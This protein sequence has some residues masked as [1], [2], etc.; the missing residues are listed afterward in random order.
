MKFCQIYTI[1]NKIDK[2]ANMAKM[3]GFLLQY[4]KQLHFNK[5]PAAVRAQFDAYLKAD[6]FRG[7]MKKW[8]D[9]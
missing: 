5:M 4:Y 7:D 8:R 3:D 1:I 6:D 9:E 2:G